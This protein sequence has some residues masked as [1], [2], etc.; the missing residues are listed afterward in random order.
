VREAV[1]A[2]PGLTALGISRTADK[3]WIAN[4]GQHPDFAYLEKLGV[5]FVPAGGKATDYFT[6]ISYEQ[7]DRYSADVIFD[8]ARSPGT[9]QASDKVGV[10][11]ALPA[12][13]AGQVHDW[14]AAAP[15]SYLAGAPIFADFAAAMAGAEKVAAAA[16]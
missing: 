6:E 15:Y 10:W 12:V 9:Q 11:Q 4:A 3:A 5:T 14:K 13:R 2:N 16:S 7:L 8:D 1:A